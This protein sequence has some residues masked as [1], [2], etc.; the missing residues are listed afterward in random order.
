MTKRVPVPRRTRFEV[1]KRDSFKCQYCG[2]AAP[3]VVLHLDHINP[4]SQGGDNDL[5]N[6]ITSCAACNMGKG[7]VPLSDTAAAERSRAQLEELQD[8]REQIEM[9]AEWRD[10]L[11]GIDDLAVDKAVAMLY[12]VNSERVLTEHGE[13]ALRRWIRRFGLDEVLASIEIAFDRYDDYATAFNKVRGICLNRERSRADP[14]LNTVFHVSNV[15]NKYLDYYVKYEAFPL[16]RAALEAG[17]TKDELM[18]S[19]FEHRSHGPWC[20]HLESLINGDRG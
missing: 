10:L 8:R 19:I 1:F 14:L 3:E 11:R 6:L 17:Y 9:M 5:T 16:I 15:A 12:E 2:K 18:A 20:Y 4:V 13:K 7:A